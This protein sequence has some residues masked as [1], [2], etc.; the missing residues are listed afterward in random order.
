M[1]L[2]IK[3]YSQKINFSFKYKPQNPLESPPPYDAALQQPIK[4]NSPNHLQ[5]QQQLILQQQQHQ[6]QR[7]YIGSSTKLISGHNTPTLPKH[8]GPTSHS[9]SIQN[10]NLSLLNTPAISASLQQLHYQQQQQM[11]QQQNL[12]PNLQYTTVQSLENRAR[13][14]NPLNG[15]TNEMDNQ[16]QPTQY[17]NIAQLNPI[18][19]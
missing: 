12:Q 11:L 2:L 7:D 14:R 5:Q 8:L 15:M 17:S 10:N 18:D 6:Q 1:K 19:V 4:K 3:F 9:Y 16:S 13:S